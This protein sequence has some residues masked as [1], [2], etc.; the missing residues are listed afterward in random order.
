MY[1]PDNVLIIS[2]DHITIWTIAR[3]WRRTKN[4][5]P[6]HHC[7]SGICLA[8][9]APFRYHQRRRQRPH[10]RLRRKTGASEKQSRIDG[11]LYFSM[12]SFETSPD[13]GREKQHS[14]NDFG[15]NV[16]PMLLEN[17]KDLFA[18]RFSG[19]WRDVGTIESYYRANM[20][21]LEPEPPLDL[22]GG[23]VRIYSNNA[24]C[25]PIMPAGGL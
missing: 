23:K 4:R 24:C 25:R 15:K 16:I 11:H 8:G 6:D 20:E 19:Y 9:S 1:N 5:G 17:G 3:C 14:L 18:Y 10:H 12:A 13:R 21:L 7:R 22:F 2:G